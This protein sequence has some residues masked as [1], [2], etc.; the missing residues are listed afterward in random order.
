MARTTNSE[1]PYGSLTFVEAAIV[2][3]YAGWF[4]QR[5]GYS[6]PEFVAGG[7][8]AMVAYI[9]LVRMSDGS[10]LN[11]PLAL[12]SI[13][14]WGCLG[15]AL[16][17]VAFDAVG[18]AHMKAAFLAEPTFWRWACAVALIA[19]ALADKQTVFTPATA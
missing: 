15:W 14:I 10:F 7:V 8:L 16:G 18:G 4:L 12:L 6:T 11:L 13:A 1:A 2:G 17:G 3:G 9:V 19:M 5:T